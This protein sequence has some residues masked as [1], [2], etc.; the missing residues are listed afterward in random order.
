MLE[1]LNTLKYFNQIPEGKVFSREVPTKREPRVKRGR[2]SAEPRLR[3]LAP[4]TVYSNCLIN[5]AR[6]PCRA[7]NAPSSLQFSLDQVCIYS[8]T[9][10]TGE[11]D[12]IYKYGIAI[13]GR[14]AFTDLTAS[15]R[16]LARVGQ[17]K[18][19]NNNPPL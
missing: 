6:M 5:T 16:S 11:Q 15:P 12:R 4:A 2:Q 10:F 8:I 13:K 19:N 3:A 17:H 18:T 1:S 14:M 7:L 9:H